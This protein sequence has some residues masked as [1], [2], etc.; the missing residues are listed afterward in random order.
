MLCCEEQAN[1]SAEDVVALVV[2]GFVKDGCSTPRGVRGRG[3]EAD[4]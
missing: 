1:L 4:L 2:N 3:A